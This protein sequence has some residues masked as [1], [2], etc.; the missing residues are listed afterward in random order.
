AAVSDGLVEGVVGALEYDPDFPTHKAN[1]RQYLNDRNRYKEVVPIRDPIILRKIRY[2]WRLQY[3]KDVVLARII[4]DPTFSVLNSLIFFN[5][6]DIVTHLQS[7]SGF[8]A[9]LFG[10]FKDG[11]GSKEKKED[12]LRFL[13]QCAAIAK[14]LQ[15]AGRNS[16]Y[17]DF[18]DHGIFDAIAFAV[19]HPESTYRATGVD[20]LMSLLEHDAVVMREYLLLFKHGVSKPDE[21]SERDPQ[22]LSP[23]QTEKPPDE[24][25]IM[26]EAEDETSEPTKS[27]HHIPLP[28]TT[29]HLLTDKLIDLFHIEP[30]LG[31]KMQLS[32]AL[33]ILFE[34]IWFFSGPLG[35]T[36]T[37]ADIA[38]VEASDRAPAGTTGAPGTDSLLDALIMRHRFDTAMVRLFAP[39]R[40][41]QAPA[42]PRFTFQEAALYEH[43]LDILSFL[44]R[45]HVSWGKRFVWAQELIPRIALLL[46]APQKHLKLAALKTL[47]ALLH[48]ND[49]FYLALMAHNNVLDALLRIVTDTMPRDNLLA[50][51]CL[52]FFESVV[53][54]QVNQ[55]VAVKPVIVHLG[56]RHKRVLE[57]I[58]YVDT[59]R[60]ILVKYKRLQGHA[61]PIDL[62]YLVE[63]AEAAQGEIDAAEM[64]RRGMTAS[65]LRYQGLREMDR[66][67]EE[68]FEG[69]DDEEEPVEIHT[70]PDETVEGDA[71]AIVISH[72]QSPRPLVDY[73]DDDDEEEEEGEQAGDAGNEEASN[74]PTISAQSAPQST[75]DTA[76]AQPRGQ[77]E[78]SL[79]SVARGIAEKRR[80]EEEDDDDELVKLSGGAKRRSSGAT[81]VSGKD[82]SD[83]GKEKTEEKEKAAAGRRGKGITFSPL[84]GAQKAVRPQQQ[85][86]QEAGGRTVS[87]GSDATASPAKRSSES[88]ESESGD[89][90]AAAGPAKKIQFRWSKGG[91]G[92]GSCLDEK[93]GEEREEKRDQGEEQ[94]ETEKEKDEGKKKE[95]EEDEDEEHADES[96]TV[97][98][99]ERANTSRTGGGCDAEQAQ[100]PS[101]SNK[102]SSAQKEETTSA[103]ERS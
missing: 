60:K 32:E 3:L 25:T 47:R 27:A 17:L 8:M 80:R 89:D 83:D 19:A 68:Y 98:D 29:A 67:E 4:D 34:P 78:K 63:E 6:V 35:R 77:D 26:G 75:T 74:T 5:Q 52:E 9:E 58:T 56:A 53:R 24:D 55:N 64:R 41:L 45:S 76:T 92:Q 31:V 46:S 79:A 14:N 81:D 85:Q 93:R 57:G 51:A 100:D 72:T 66:A 37:P 69:S 82:E 59:F 97:S 21:E 43:L 95:E 84:G 10:L 65:Q 20:I 91:G 16:L 61:E 11:K 88:M 101:D 44:T 1:H 7:N 94:K 28:T 103:G 13:Y 2:T 70:A 39:L 96:A 54:D 71:H 86:Q 102:E 18:I 62:S 12:A 15:P 33:R 99:S 73:P 42:M 40:G 48:L 90:G 87:G 38:R 49:P 23:K 22:Q 36:L 30:D 50:S